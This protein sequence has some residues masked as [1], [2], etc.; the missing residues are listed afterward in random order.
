MN[1][2]DNNILCYKINE[3]ELLEVIN[4]IVSYYLFKEEQVLILTDSYQE[5][6]LATNIFK[7]LDKRLLYLDGNYN[8]EELISYLLL[9]LQEQT[10]KTIISKVE[11]LYRNINKK[12]DILKQISNFFN[13]CNYDIPLIEKYILTGRKLDSN[14]TY[15]KYYRTFRIK[16]P[17][18]NY[19]YNELKE[20]CK[21]IL[22]SGLS[23][24]YIQYRRF[25]DNDIYNYLKLP[26][27]YNLINDSIYLINTIIDNKEIE[28]NLIVSIYTEDF[29]DAYISNEIIDEDYI[30]SLTNIVNLKYNYKLLNKTITKKWFNIF[31]KYN[32]NKDEENLKAFS[33]IK[34][35]IYN[36]YLNNYNYL[37]KLKEKLSFLK[38]IIRE[39]KYNELIITIIKSKNIYENLNLYKRIFNIAYKNRN[40]FNTI[41]NISSIEE[42]I[43]KYCYDDL[44]EKKYID[45]LLTILP[46]LKCYLDI[47]EEEIKNTNII[48]LYKE[49]DSVI[50]SIY[51]DNYKKNTIMSKAINKRWDNKLRIASSK[52][53]E[54]VNTIREEDLNSFFPCTV[55]TL[56]NENIQELINK[57]INFNKIIVISKEKDKKIDFESMAKISK[58]II[59]LDIDNKK[60]EFNFYKDKTYVINEN[61]EILSEIKC[62]LL[63]K[64]INL[65]IIINNP[66]MEIKINEHRIILLLNNSLVS[67]DVFLYKYYM[68]N[69]I[70]IYRLWNRDWWVNKY[71]ELNKINEYIN[72]LTISNK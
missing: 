34:D 12:Q 1:D 42:N 27:D 4:E 40:I 13:N 23:T 67:N 19:N 17:F 48:E 14:H 43:L 36:E 71:K 61:N 57:N 59:S 37:N 35:E 39:E 54:N 7:D 6:I 8:I 72:K 69:N 68:D 21:N 58:T 66:N 53:K 30:L 10:G 32:K 18:K 33:K 28:H 22:S 16:N 24:Q 5:G 63:D 70:N 11:L 3:N 50:N 9:N 65:Q 62:F 29:I 2:S 64:N 26:L 20:A 15:N 46:M 44:E 47:E 55:A 60:R 51:T 56:S 49:Y 38:S 45:E 41:D 31:K 25:V 52:L